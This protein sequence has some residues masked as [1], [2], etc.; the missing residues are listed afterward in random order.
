MKIKVPVYSFFSSSN[1]LI[2]VIDGVINQSASN[3]VHVY[4]TSIARF[5]EILVGNRLKL[6]II[7]VGISEKG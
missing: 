7:P 3:N 1:L 2:L 6:P 4:S 5:Y